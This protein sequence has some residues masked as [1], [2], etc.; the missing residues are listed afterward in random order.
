MS[1]NNGAVR[2]GAGY[3][4]GIMTAPLGTTAPT[5]PTASY[6]SGWL[7][8]GIIDESGIT[9]SSDLSTNDVVGRDGSLVRRVK[10]TESNTIHFI[11]IERNGVTSD[12]FY[13][14]STRVTATGITTISK[15]T[16]ITV[17]QAFAFD[18]LDNGIHT[19]SIIPKGEIDVFGDVVYQDSDVTKYDM[20]MV[21]Y[22]NASGIWMITITDDPNVTSS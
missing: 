6:A 16:R 14:G 10:Q 3:L 19:R 9:E 15:K 20:T 2:T 11:A 1:T 22:P 13:P 8:L 4:G 5:T 7:D 18:E 12:L 21:C 17:P